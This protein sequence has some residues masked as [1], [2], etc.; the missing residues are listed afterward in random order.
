[1]ILD[2]ATDSETHATKGIDITTNFE[3]YTTLTPPQ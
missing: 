2:P 3:E 1:M